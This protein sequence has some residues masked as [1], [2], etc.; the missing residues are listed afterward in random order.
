MF[1]LLFDYYLPYCVICESLHP[2]YLFRVFVRKCTGIS[3][4]DSTPL[5][6]CRNQ[7]IHIHKTFKG[8]AQRGKCSTS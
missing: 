8:I 7:R 1:R 2:I 3:F 6:V 5:R 4:V